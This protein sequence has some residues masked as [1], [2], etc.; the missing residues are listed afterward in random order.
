MILIEK[1]RR[2]NTIKMTMILRIQPIIFI[3]VP[4]NIANR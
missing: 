4:G 3:K 1:K 2:T